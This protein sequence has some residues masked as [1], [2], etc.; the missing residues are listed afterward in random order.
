MGVSGQH[1]AS[2]ALYPGTHCTGGWV[3]PQ[4][5]CTQRQEEK[6]FRLCRGSNLDRRVDK[7]VARHYTDWAT[8]LTNKLTNYAKSQEVEFGKYVSHL[9]L[10]FPH[11]LSVNNQIPTWALCPVVFCSADTGCSCTSSTRITVRKKSGESNLYSMLPLMTGRSQLQSRANSTW[12]CS[13]SKSVWISFG[14]V[15]QN[16]VR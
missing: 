6:S 14:W 3:G 12:T 16:T 5:V 15:T 11:L 7:P 1:H 9:E 2:A 10:T 8:R 4:P 13:T